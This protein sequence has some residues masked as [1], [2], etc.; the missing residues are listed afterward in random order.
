MPA[1]PFLVAGPLIGGWFGFW[2]RPAV[3]FGKKLSFNTVMMR[4]ANLQGVDAALVNTA[5][6]SFNRMLI[7]VALGAV[8]GLCLIIAIRRVR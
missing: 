2:L 5:E 8:L 7:G 1:W 6:T 4:G 3:G